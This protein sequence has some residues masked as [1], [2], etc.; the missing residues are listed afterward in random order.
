M[1]GFEA[2][3]TEGGWDVVARDGR[4][5]AIRAEGDGVK[6]HDNRKRVADRRGTLEFQSPVSALMWCAAEMAAPVITEG[7]V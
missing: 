1:K 2:I 3:E 6:V 5:F 4:R 7:G